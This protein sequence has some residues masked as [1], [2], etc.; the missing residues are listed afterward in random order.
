MGEGHL[1][2]DPSGNYLLLVNAR[3]LCDCPSRVVRLVLLLSNPV[4]LYEEYAYLLDGPE[5]E[6]A[7]VAWPDPK[8]LL[9][10]EA[11]PGS[12]RLYRVDLNAGEDIAFSAWDE[13]GLEERNPIPVRPVDKVLL[14]E[15]PL[16]RPKG[17]ALEDKDRL[18]TVMEDKLQ[19]IHLPSALW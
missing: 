9:V 8:N 13:G 4:G 1:A 5:A 10:L 12:A 15:L 6:V 17:L 11:Q 2:L 3:P 7:G 19:R 16:S 18:L 14:A